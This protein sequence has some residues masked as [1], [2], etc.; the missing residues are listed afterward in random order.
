MIEETVNHI[1]RFAGIVIG[2]VGVMI[3]LVGVIR[4]FFAYL[5]AEFD[6][7]DNNWQLDTIRYSLWKYLLLW[8][9]FLIAADI[10]ETVFDPTLEHI[11]ILG[12]IVIIRTVLNFF[13]NKEIKHIKEELQQ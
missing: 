6:H 11:A 9:E 10:L 4:E 13:L 12:W 3:I 7:I 8:L 2:I 5:K 1:V